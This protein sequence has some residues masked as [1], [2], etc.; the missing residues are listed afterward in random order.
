M[1]PAGTFGTAVASLKN[2]AA[3]NHRPLQEKQR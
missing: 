3:G 2:V 1:P